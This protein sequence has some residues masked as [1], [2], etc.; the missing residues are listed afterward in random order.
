[1][2]FKMENLTIMEQYCW[3][4]SR[5]MCMILERIS[6]VLFWDAITIRSLIWESWLTARLL[7]REQSKR[8]LISLAYLV[9]LLLVWMKWFSMLKNSQNIILMFLY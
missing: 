2:L 8:R 5:E 1:M 7:L 6:L 4:L 9:S 3:L